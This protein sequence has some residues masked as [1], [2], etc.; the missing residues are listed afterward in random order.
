M[1]T[2]VIDCKTG[3][4]GA[5]G[6]TTSS[7]SSRNGD[8]LKQTTHYYD[9]RVKVHKNNGV[10]FVAAGDADIISRQKNHFFSFGYLDHTEKGI[11]LSP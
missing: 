5:D 2:V 10:V 4:I 11:I 1:T 9:D 7:F 6:Q 8:A 3:T